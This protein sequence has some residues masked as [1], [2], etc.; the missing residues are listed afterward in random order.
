MMLQTNESNMRIKST[1]HYFS[2]VKNIL[3]MYTSY[4]MLCKFITDIHVYIV[5]KS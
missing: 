2:Y 1:Y 5:V 3:Q 4:T